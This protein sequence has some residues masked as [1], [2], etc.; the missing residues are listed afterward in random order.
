MT[1]FNFSAWAIRHASLTRYFLVLLLVGGVFG[2]FKLGQNE[3]P[4]FTFRV[5]VV[6]AYLPGATAKQVETLLTDKIERK[7]Q[8]LPWLDKLRSY[9]K[10]GEAMVFVQVRGDTPPK[11]IPAL[12]YQVRKKLGDIRPLLPPETQGPFFN[13]EFGDTYGALYALRGEGFSYPE[14]K[15]AADAA[16]QALLRVKAVAK[17]DLF[18]V[19]DEKIFIEFSHKKFAQMGLSIESIINALNAHNA[20]EPAGTLDTAQESVRLRV[21]G[22]YRT[23]AELENLPLTAPNGTHLRL[24]DFA[25]ISRGLTDPPQARVRFNGHEVVALG[26]TMAQGG[27]IIALGDNLHEAVLRLQQAL[28]AGLVIEQIADQPRVVRHS[29]NEFLK[30][31]LEAVVIVLAVSFLSLGLSTRPWRVDMRPGLVVALSIPLVL[32]ITFLFMWLLNIDFQK[33]SLGALIIALGLLVDDAIIAVEMMVRKLEEGFDRVSAAT[34]AYT[35]TAAPMLTGTLITVAG[36]L[37]VG[38][39]QS[40]AGEYTFSIFAVNAIALITSWVVAVWFTPYLG[41]WLLKERKG[42]QHALFDTPHYQR[43]RALITW[44]VRHR[45]TTLLITLLMFGVSMAGFGLIQQQF[46][47]DSNREELNVELWLPEGSSF[48][49]TDHEARR[50]EAVL[51]RPD[52]AQDIVSVV[53]YIGQGSPRFFLPLDQ[54]LNHS[55]FAQL[56]VLTR[57]LS[58]R[59][60]VAEK[61]RHALDEEVPALRGRINALPAGPP[62]PYPVQFQVVGPEVDTVRAI[63]DQVANVMREDPATF[64]VNDNWNN[65]IKVLRLEVDQDKARAVGVSSQSISRALQSLLS[66]MTIG[67]FRERDKLIAVVMRQAADERDALSKIQDANLPTASGRS[68]PLSQVVRAELAFEPGIIWRD[69]RQPAITVQSDI[70]TGHQ[71]PFVTARIDPKLDTLRATL[72]PGYRITVGGASEESAAAQQSI[73]AIMPLMLVAVFTLLMWQLRSFSRSLMVFLTAPLGLIGAVW[74]LLILQAPFGFVAMLGVIALAGMIMRNSV[75]LIDQ[76]E[77]DIKAGH[78]A[79]TAI[80]EA[81]VRRA[82]PIMLTAAAA[83]LAMI[84][85]TRSIFWG[86]MAVAIMGGLLVATLLTLLFLPAL[87]AAWFGVKS[88]QH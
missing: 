63:A 85:L 41:V 66:G 45:K 48:A 69:H 10:P 47:P 61:L 29:V 50:F 3:D 57:S 8:E 2:Y 40:A 74:M 44:C 80:I 15:D 62:V 14:L 5:M 39:A 32:S 18:G 42:E 12:W 6:S 25:R 60:R 84:P 28:P 72:P 22:Q 46:F 81:A 31:L 55:N 51:A 53:S 64:G 4:S 77:Q 49:A 67:Q 75:I 79:M 23:L 56:I 26:V 11:E 83:I 68:I 71:G 59:A 34:F 52:I 21:S 43:L 17:V 73:N 24:A 9:S 87:Y 19:Q 58:A 78:D 27:D 35:S 76:I 13:D 37:P 70:K 7:L 82:R 36:F 30:T 20:I 1:R 16:R 86:P 54:Q 33:I 65:A 88:A 38:F